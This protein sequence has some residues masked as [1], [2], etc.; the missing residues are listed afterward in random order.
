MS[1]LKNYS[2][3]TEGNESPTVYHTWAGLSALSSIISR[4]VWIDMGFFTVYPNMYILFVGKAGI[5]KS[6]AMNI[7]RKLVRQIKTIPISP[8]SITREAMTQMMSEEGS[9]CQKTFKHDGKL[10]TYTHLSIFC[11]ELVTLL[12]AGGNATGMIET[13]TDIWDQDLFEVK[14]KNRGTD[15]IQGPYITICG[16]ITTETMNNLMNTKIISSGF[17]RRCLFVHS[18][19]YGTPVPV[20]IITDDQKNAWDECVKRAKELQNIDGEFEWSADARKFWHDFYI[21]NHDR[22]AKEDNG[23]MQG[24]LQSKPEYVLKVAMLTTLSESDKLIITPEHLALAD[25]FI[26]QIEPEMSLVFEGTGRNELS[27]IASAIERMIVDSPKAIPIKRIYA[28]FYNDANT[29][30]IDKI[31]QHLARVDKI[32]TGTVTKGKTEIR[33]A[34]S[35]KLVPEKPNSSPDSESS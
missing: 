25:E 9:P 14:T 35:P 31:L 26:R 15:Y 20:P 6:T 23:V 17:S 2:K 11:N 19:D 8:P 22:K 18:N 29:E 32:K 4:R 27:P 21:K 24:F 10:K 1:F 7:A 33:I 5:K 3:F 30:E 13:I 28:T 16:C 12:N 34:C